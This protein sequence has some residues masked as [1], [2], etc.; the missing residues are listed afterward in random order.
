MPETLLMTPQA[1]ET[2]ALWPAAWCPPAATHQSAGASSGHALPEVAGPRRQQGLLLLGDWRAER[3]QAAL[4]RH[5][6]ACWVCRLCY[7]P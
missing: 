1:P 5:L 4:Q 2:E 6:V 3:V 7:M